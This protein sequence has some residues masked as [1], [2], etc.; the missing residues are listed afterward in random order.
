MVRFLACERRGCGCC[1]VKGQAVCA[2]RE[3]KARWCTPREGEVYVSNESEVGCVGAFGGEEFKKGVRAFSCFGY[4]GG[5]ER[6]G[7][8]GWKE[9]G[10]GERR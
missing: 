10:P 2:W 5:W 4:G 1:T 9:R 8:G 6:G 7:R 3:G